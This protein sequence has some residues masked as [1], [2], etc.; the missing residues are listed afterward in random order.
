MAACVLPFRKPRRA[1]SQTKAPPVRGWINRL[2]PGELEEYRAIER[3]SFFEGRTNLFREG[4][5]SECLFR[6]VEGQVKI[7][8]N[9][10]SGRR[11]AVAMASPGE[12]LDLAS[13]VTRRPYCVTAETVYPCVLAQVSSEKFNRFLSL[14]PKLYEL[15]L[16]DMVAQYDV[17]CGTIRLLGLDTTIQHRL[18]RLLLRWC[19]SRG[20]TAHDGVR[21]S[22]AMTHEE[23]GEFVGAS[24]ETVTR[25]LSD[26]RERRLVEVHGSTILVPDIANL[27]LF[28]AA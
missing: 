12:L 16:C 28:A 11:L 27:A 9:S 15:L 4:D 1:A 14:R 17:F 25:V 19:Y 10:S 20:E 2:Q 24:R 13:V 3:S 8:I 26:F 7:S 21:I 22:V 6:L 5:E 23:I 18:A